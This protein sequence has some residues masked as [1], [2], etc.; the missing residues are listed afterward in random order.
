M[1]N[2]N[3]KSNEWLFSSKFYLRIRVRDKE[4]HE[5]IRIINF[6]VH[7][8]EHLLNSAHI[9]KMNYIFDFQHQVKYYNRQYLCQRNSALPII[10]SSGL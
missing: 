3:S 7:M 6:A 5:R 1:T 2:N 4:V 10:F 9:S 8:N